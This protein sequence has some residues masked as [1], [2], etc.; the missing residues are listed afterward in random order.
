MEGA[1]R[2]RGGASRGTLAVPRSHRPVPRGRRD[3]DGA[4][5]RAWALRWL[6]ELQKSEVGAGDAQ[7]P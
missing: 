3:E 6:G 5:V 7:E 1:A 2:Q 4:V